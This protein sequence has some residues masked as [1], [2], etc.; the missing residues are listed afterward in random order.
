M[1]VILHRTSR[2]QTINFYTD[3][4]DNGFIKHYIVVLHNSSYDN[5]ITDSAAV[6]KL[7]K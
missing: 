6:I 5:T 3:L 1:T 7:N 2:R 4:T